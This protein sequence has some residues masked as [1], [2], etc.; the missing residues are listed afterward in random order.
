MSDAKPYKVECQY[1][2]SGRTA[3]I[4][5]VRDPDGKIVVSELARC[6]VDALAIRLNAAYAAGIASQAA[7]IAE[8]EGALA[9]ICDGACWSLGGP[10]HNIAEIHA[11]K[12][13]TARALLAKGES[14]AE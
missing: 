9:D 13:K 14:H 6:N 3:P 5:V 10:R 11:S 2:L 4:Y 1:S 7:R 12:I 8:L